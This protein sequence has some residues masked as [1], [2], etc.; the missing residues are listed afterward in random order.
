M[1][2]NS[3]YFLT[4]PRRLTRP[5]ALLYGTQL[6][7]GCVRI[8]KHFSLSLEDE[9]HA[10]RTS[11]FTCFYDVTQY[12]SSQLHSIRLADVQLLNV[13]T[14]TEP[15]GSTPGTGRSQSL[16]TNAEAV[17]KDL[18]GIGHDQMCCCLG[19]LRHK[20]RIVGASAEIST[21]RRS[22]TNTK[23]YRLSQTARQLQFANWP[24]EDIVNRAMK[25]DNRRLK[26]F[27]TNKQAGRPRLDEVI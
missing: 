13:P 22:K 9:L 2:K 11:T 8:L 6:T 16:Q 23:H 17:R 18:K 4:A 20:T 1:S 3:G 24:L 21:G 7:K 10:V 12:F 14:C 26:S 27:E 15:L 19:R 5:C 25:M